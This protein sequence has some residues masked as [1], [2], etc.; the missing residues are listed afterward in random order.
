[1]AARD[2]RVAELEEL[3][4]AVQNEFA[5]FAQREHSRLAELDRFERNWKCCALHFQIHWTLRIPP[6]SCAIVC[7]CGLIQCR[8]QL[9][10][11][12]CKDTL[13]KTDF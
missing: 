11:S 9:A 10:T 6:A 1:M 7:V 5:E 2:D 8:K 3:F 12:S 4:T 13:Q